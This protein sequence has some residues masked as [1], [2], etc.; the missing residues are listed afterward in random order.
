MYG[1]VSRNI[2]MYRFTVNNYCEPAKDLTCTS[3]L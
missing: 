2:I 1:Y 3:T